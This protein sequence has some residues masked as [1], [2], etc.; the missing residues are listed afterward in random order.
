MS[1]ELLVTPAK[2]QCSLKG[3]RGFAH[4]KRIDRLQLNCCFDPFRFGNVD[5]RVEICQQLR[6]DTIPRHHRVISDFASVDF[7]SSIK[8]SARAHIK[9]FL[10]PSESEGR[11]DSATEI[12]LGILITR[13]PDL[14]SICAMESESCQLPGFCSR[15]IARWRRGQLKISLFDR[16]L[17]G[18]QRTSASVGGE[19]EPLG[20]RPAQRLRSGIFFDT[21]HAR[22]RPGAKKCWM[23]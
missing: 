16:E 7:S 6:Q 18:D 22:G 13:L 11:L 10:W 1:L 9:R 14:L 12:S 20:P 5:A 15:P 8:T 21:E 2:E 3:K 17:R 19:L 4:E 23:R